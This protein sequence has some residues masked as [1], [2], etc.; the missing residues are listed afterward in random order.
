MVLGKVLGK[1]LDMVL[2]SSLEEDNM[3][4]TLLVGSMVLGMDCSKDHGPSSS[5]LQVQML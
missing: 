2:H 3:V 1:E 5:S 4:C